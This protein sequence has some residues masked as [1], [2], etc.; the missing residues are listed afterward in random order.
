M[1]DN[2]ERFKTTTFGGFDKEEVLQELQKMKENA[3]AEKAQILRELEEARRDCARLSR[4]LQAKDGKIAE[5]Q[6]AIVTRDRERMEMD[7]T[8]REKY[9]S[10][11]D[12]YETIGSLIYESKIRAKQIARET[13]EER[14]KILSKAQEEADQI[15]EKAE[16]AIQKRLQD[17]QVEIDDR[18]SAGRQQFEFV[19]DELNNALELFSKLQ[20]QFMHSYKTIQEIVRDHPEGPD[21]EEV[22]RAVP[23]EEAVKGE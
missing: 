17:V 21:M 5:L 4:E 1:G 11:I 6:E 3:H 18:T 13:E 9:Q 7:R 15:R 23:E 8:V 12:N 14:Q 16:Q 19:Q 10:Y 20:K 2:E 22:S